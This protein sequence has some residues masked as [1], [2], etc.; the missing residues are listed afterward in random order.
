MSIPKHI[1]QTWK[2]HTIIPDNF[3]YWS[4]TWKKHNPD[5]KYTLWDDA[6]NRAFISDKFPWFLQTFD[7][8]RKNIQRA[9]AVRYFFL[10][11]YGGIYADMDFECLKPFNALLA[12]NKDATVILGRMSSDNSGWIQTQAI[13]NALMLSRPRDPFWLYVFQQL[14]RNKNVQMVEDATGPGMLSS[15]IQAFNNRT[16]H[17]TVQRSLF[18]LVG[19]RVQASTP[20]IYD[21]ILK[22]LGAELAPTTDTQLLLLEPSYFYPISWAINGNDRNK[23][24]KNTN[25]TSLTQTS[26]EKYK[27]AYA[28][29]YWTHSW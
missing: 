7:G 4:Q 26:K 10:Y 28:V 18:N 20:S 23:A 24:L 5:Y 1:F 16:H 13:P 27:S 9:D 8:Y 6:E 22:N 21:T 19:N 25:Y 3:R 11:Y 15:A 2:S 17:T 12:A 29:T 14:L